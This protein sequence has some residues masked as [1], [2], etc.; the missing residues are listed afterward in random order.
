[1]RI[2][3]VILIF[4]VSA[5]LLGGTAFAINRNSP[6]A[7]REA[8]EQLIQMTDEEHRAVAEQAKKRPAIEKKFAEQLSI[9]Y[10]MPEEVVAEV[11][12]ENVLAS[13]LIRQR[14]FLEKQESNKLIPF[15]ITEESV[16]KAVIKEKAIIAEAGKRGLLP[17]PQEIDDYVQW[18]KD[19]LAEALSNTEN[20]ALQTM[21]KD[22]WNSYLAGLGVTEQEFW[23]NI[24]PEEYAKGLTTVKLRD[25]VMNEVP[26]EDTTPEE[27][28]Q[29]QSL[30]WENFTE[31]LISNAEV[32]VINPSLFKY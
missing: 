8:Q 18:Q 11:N 20:S 31:Q 26:L 19:M 3:P 24:A 30:A 27:Y 1:M 28:L 4:G 16:V 5:I 25:S 7:F 23:S 14:A 13:D 22:V 12:G 17:M 29:Q 9:A 32:S 2:I 21:N 15:T 6:P 10:S